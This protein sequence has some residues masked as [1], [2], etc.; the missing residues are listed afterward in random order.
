MKPLTA[1]YKALEFIL[2]AQSKHLTDKKC[3][4][5]VE[6]AKFDRTPRPKSELFS[7]GF[8]KESILPDDVDKK[9][10][11]YCGLR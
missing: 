10:I 8:S 5:P 2:T 4:K 1:A 9:K 6:K 3:T 7:L 11:L